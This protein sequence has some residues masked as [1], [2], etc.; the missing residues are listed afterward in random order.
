MSKRKYAPWAPAPWDHAGQCAGLTDEYRDF[1][2]VAD[3]IRVAESAITRGIIA[4]EVDPLEGVTVEHGWFV[5]SPSHDR[6]NG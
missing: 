4:C 5:A 1:I 3:R 2:C 6:R